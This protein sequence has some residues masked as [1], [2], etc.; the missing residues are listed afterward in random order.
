MR[1]E[2][3]NEDE[4]LYPNQ[5]VNIRLLVNT[6]HNVI[7]IPTAAIQRG[8]PGTFVYII[9]ADDTV[10]VRV[11]Q[12]GPSEGENVAVTSGLNPGDRVVVDGAD[13]LRAGSKIS[14]RAAT[15]SSPA[16]PASGA[17]TA[18]GQPAAAPGQPTAPSPPTA[19]APGKGI[20][21][22]AATTPAGGDE[23]QKPAHR[24]KP[25]QQ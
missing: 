12:L 2:F 14:L 20:P 7:V 19:A 18:P 10:A 1:A 23:Q 13:K 21:N 24:K 6:L 5:F 22:P 9:N 3:A 17:T 25:D 15:G 16:A 8:A 4:V 11:V